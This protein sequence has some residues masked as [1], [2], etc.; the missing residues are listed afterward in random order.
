[1]NIQLNIVTCPKCP[2]EFIRDNVAAPFLQLSV[3]T[4]RDN[5]QCRSR[6]AQTMG[7]EYVHTPSLFFELEMATHGCQETGFILKMYMVQCGCTRFNNIAVC[8][9]I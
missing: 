4:V 2:E 7:V 9:L 8:I 6:N 1:M 5:V 3:V